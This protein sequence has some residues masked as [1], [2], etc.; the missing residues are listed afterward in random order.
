MAGVPLRV[1]GV[2]PGSQATGYGVIEVRGGRTSVVTHG[3]VRPPRGGP[4]PRRLLTVGDRLR[5]VLAA[6][7]ASEVAVETMFQGKNPRSAHVLAQVRGVV[8]LTAAQA[9]CEVFEYAP[10]QVKQAATGYG[11]ADKEQVRT[12]V[13]LLLSLDPPPRSTDVTDALAVAWC[14]GSHRAGHRVAPGEPPAG[15]AAR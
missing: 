8:L 9:G 12:M 4:L 5:E 6:T 14:H 1:L 13:G 15:G 11:R 7:G 10:M 2:D 3:V